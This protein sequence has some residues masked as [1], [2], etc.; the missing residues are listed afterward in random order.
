METAPPS[1]WKSALR[2]FAFALL[3]VAILLGLVT[4]QYQTATDRAQSKRATLLVRGGDTFMGLYYIA[5]G[6][7]WPEDDA[8]WFLQSAYELYLSAAK[9]DPHGFRAKMSL[10]MFVRTTGD[11]PEAA[12]L[13]PPVVVGRTSQ[14]ERNTLKSVYPIVGTPFPALIALEKSHDYLFGY[15]A[16]PL[17]LARAYR[18][19]DKQEQADRVLSEAAAGWRPLLYRMLAVAAFNGLMVLAG[20]VGLVVALLLRR[21][22]EP[23]PFPEKRWGLREAT[24]ALLLWVVAMGV[25]GIGVAGL[26]VQSEPPL[27]LILL[28]SVLAGLLAIDWVWLAAGFQADLGWRLSGA[29]R[30]AAIGL[31][32]AGL[33]VM[34]A[35][36]LHQV[37]LT[38]L[39]R[40]PLDN[41]VIPLLVAPEGLVDKITLV[42]GAGLVAPALEET[43]FRG[44]LF[45]ALRQ[46]WSF[47][48]AA[49]ASSALF[50]AVHFDLAGAASYFLLGL[51]FAYLFERT[52]SLVAPAVAHAGF[53][54]FNLAVILA[55]FG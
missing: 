44:V 30:Q 40:S 13:M 12:S 15:G 51:V 29:P 17:M 47:W 7:N 38:V 37:L 3:A 2:T 49:A 11:V 1:D 16:G 52:R 25:L 27:W 36:A 34:P 14:E 22:A 20:L 19:M 32:T 26:V 24:E 5:H 28:P 55:L 43:L 39:G 8:A 41:P 45:G 42:I 18:E 10:A 54:L 9:A 48:P 35:L 4:E 53:N 31:C 33:A 23:A 46:R 50:S 21:R 6:A